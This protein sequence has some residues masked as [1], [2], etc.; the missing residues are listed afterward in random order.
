[1]RRSLVGC[2]LLVFCGGLAGCGGSPTTDPARASSAP[3][4]TPSSS[5]ASS[6]SPS[7]T[8]KA[9]TTAELKKGLVT[10]HDLGSPWVQP[11]SVNT[12]GSKGEVCPGHKSA[13]T[14]V[15]SKAA[16]QANFTEGKGTGKNIASFSLST[17]PQPDGSALKAA[18]AT[19]HKVC[20]TYRD[21][22]GY[23]VVR[24]VEGPKSVSNADELV[25]TWSDRIYYDKAHKKLAYARH[26]LVVR[27]GQLV[28][29]VSYAFLTTKKDPHAKDFTRAS[30][31]LAVQ[32]KKNAETFA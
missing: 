11:K 26:Y 29:Y 1:V 31:L 13:T 7:A 15:L 19:D 5:S 27:T 10:A 23:Y 8:P 18:Y 22:T 21:A 16:A 24:S 12:A 9:L 28:T 25:T 14:K 6:A 3:A 20:G 2:L 4:A 17:L 32:L 30:K